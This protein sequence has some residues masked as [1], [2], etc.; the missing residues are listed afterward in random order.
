MLNS[1]VPSQ[2]KPPLLDFKEV[3]GLDLKAGAPY[4][5]KAPS[6]EFKVSKT[7][8]CKAKSANPECPHWGCVV[9][10]AKKSNFRICPWGWFFRG[11]NDIQ[12]M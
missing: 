3:R 2:S 8:D 11:V 6:W 4:Q 10:L 12:R 7:S 5:F 1:R 9:L